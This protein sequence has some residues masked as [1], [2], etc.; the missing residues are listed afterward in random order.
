LGL[1]IWI[2]LILIIC[3]IVII[4]LF[5]LSKKRKKRS[6]EITDIKIE[7]TNQSKQIEQNLTQHTHI[8]LEKPDTQNEK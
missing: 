1:I 2:I 4:T 6:E 3:V 8:S 7:S 5:L